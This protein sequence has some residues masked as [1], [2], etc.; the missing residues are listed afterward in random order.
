MKKNLIILIIISG[1]IC[2][3]ISYTNAVND[4]VKGGNNINWCKN[5]LAK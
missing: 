1:F 4:C 2:L 3:N 5:E